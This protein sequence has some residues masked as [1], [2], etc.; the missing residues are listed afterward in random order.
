MPP[1]S[2]SS[3]QRHEPLTGTASRVQRW[4]LVEQNGPWGPEAPPRSRLGDDVRAAL[5]ATAD[6]AGA[7]LLLIRRPP[8]APAVDH[9]RRLALMRRSPRPPT[10]RS[11]FLADSGAGAER[12]VERAV[13][14]DRELAALRVDA[15]G[16]WTESLV[17]LLL[18]CTHGRHDRCCSIRGGVVARTL[19][20]AYP[21]ATWESS[22]VGGDRL[23]AN[24]VV[25]PAGLYLGRVPP[26]QAVSVAAEVFAG[27]VPLRFDR[28][29]STLPL[30]AQ[31]AQHFARVELRRPGLADLQLGQVVR[32]TD[33]AS[34]VTLRGAV[35]TVIVTVRASW[36][37]QAAILSC[38]Q[39]TPRRWPTFD[40][41]DLCVVRDHQPA[42]D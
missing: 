38:G 41:L 33:G 24:L 16:D 31:A 27:R 42:G 21:A 4:L 35:D 14:S 26:E 25:L 13:H 20:A 34:Q 17:P 37:A 2:E 32:G 18:V 19:S 30:V 28:G 6:A 8:P 22:H 12:L 7:R 39:E 9:D 15:P 1:C 10:A 36:S 23:A 5:L 11:V 40:L 3:R 29:R